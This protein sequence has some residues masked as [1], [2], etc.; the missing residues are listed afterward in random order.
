VRAS[1]YYAVAAAQ[2]ADALAFDRA[3]KLYRLALD[4]GAHD[5]TDKLR[6]QT[7]LGNALA[8]AGR[9]AD[10]GTLLAHP[11]HARPAPPGGGTAAKPVFPW[12]FAAR[13]HGNRPGQ[14]GTGLQTCYDS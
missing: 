1:R 12:F 5:V 2:A 7:E 8:N 9:G 10:S 11:H 3:A 13:L 14:R 4:L 6:L